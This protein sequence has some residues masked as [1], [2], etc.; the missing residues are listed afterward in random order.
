MKTI[1]TTPSARNMT[2]IIDV[3]SHIITN[4]GSQAPMDKLPAWSIEQALSLM[5]EM[6]SPHQFYRCP[7]RPITRKDRKPANSRG[8]LMKSW[9]TSSQN[10]P[11]ASEPWRRYRC[12]R[13]QTVCSKRWRTPSIR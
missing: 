12:W 11:R 10:I 13:R 7:I 1:S 5:D 6:E 2:G 8:E 4:I 3:H 9:P